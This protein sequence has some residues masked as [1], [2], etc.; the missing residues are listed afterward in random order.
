[1]DLAKG[2]NPAR[3]YVGELKKVLL[4]RKEREAKSNH[5]KEEKKLGENKTTGYGPKGYINRGE[6]RGWAKKQPDT[7]KIWPGLSEQK[8]AEK[9]E[10]GLWGEPSGKI[11]SLIEGEKKEAEIRRAEL[12]KKESATRYPEKKI[13]QKE[14]ELIDRFLGKK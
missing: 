4:V 8:R 3:N 6:F 9:I 13:I 10:K 7:W 1:M 12:A 14:I 5:L 11:G 2:N